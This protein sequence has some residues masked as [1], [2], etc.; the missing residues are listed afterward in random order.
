MNVGQLYFV[1]P[2][3]YASLRDVATKFF[4]TFKIAQN[5]VM[6]VE[7]LDIP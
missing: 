7:C 2:Q 3:N 1:Y 6:N 4:L 5:Y